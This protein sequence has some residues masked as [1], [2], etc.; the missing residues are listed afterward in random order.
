MQDHDV[1]A[2]EVITGGYVLRCSCGWESAR[3]TRSTLLEEWERHR[4]AVPAEHDA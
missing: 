2:I 3:L 1:A 4:L